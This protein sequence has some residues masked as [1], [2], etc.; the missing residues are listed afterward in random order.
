MRASPIFS[1]LGSRSRLEWWRGS[2]IILLGLEISSKSQVKPGAKAVADLI[3]LTQALAI[4]TKILHLNCRIESTTQE[5]WQIKY[6]IHLL[7]G[8]PPSITDSQFRG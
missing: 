5:R 7:T 2:E 8:M 3:I 4:A 6:E 1:F